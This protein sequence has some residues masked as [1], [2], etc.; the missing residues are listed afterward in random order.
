MKTKKILPQV[1]SRDA[2]RMRLKN[3]F[4]RR[5]KRARCG[6]LKRYTANT[7]RGGD[8]Q[9]AT[10]VGAPGDYPGLGRERQETGQSQSQ[11]LGQNT[12]HWIIQVSSVLTHQAAFVSRVVHVKERMLAR[13]Q[14]ITGKWLTEDRMKTEHKLREALRMQLI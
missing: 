13:E 9:R 8:L 1:M 12:L 4:V 10:G 6:S 14:E 5:R 2:L 11:G 3:A 7:S